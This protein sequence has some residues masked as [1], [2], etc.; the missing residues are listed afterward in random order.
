MGCG[1]STSSGGQGGKNGKM[2]SSPSIQI[3]SSAAADKELCKSPTHF[4]HLRKRKSQKSPSQQK[5]PS[6][7]RSFP[8]SPSNE[9]M[10]KLSPRFGKADN[11]SFSEKEKSTESKSEEEKEL[12]L[13][14]ARSPSRVSLTTDHQQHNNGLLSPRYGTPRKDHQNQPVSANNSP[15]PSI[16]SQNLD[17]RDPD[18][19]TYHKISNPHSKVV[20]Q[21]FGQVG[22]KE[23]GHLEHL[24]SSGI[25]RRTRPTQVVQLFQRDSDGPN[26]RAEGGRQRFAPTGWQWAGRGV[27][28]CQALVQHASYDDN[29]EKDRKLWEATNPDLFKVEKSYKGPVL[30]LPLKNSH[31]ELMIEHFKLNKTLHPR[32][33]V[34]VFHEARKLFKSMPTISYLSTS[35]SGQV[36][37]C[38]DLHGKFD[39]LC[40]ILHKNGFP[41]LDNPYV[42]NGDFVDRELPLLQGGQSIE[43]LIILLTLFILNPT[44]VSLN[45]GNHEDHIM[46]LR[47]GFVKEL[48]TKYKDSASLIIRLMEDIFSWL[49]LATVIDNDIFVAHGGISDKTDVEILKKIPRHRPPIMDLN[50]GSGKKSVNVEEWRQILDVLWSDPKTQVG[51]TANAFRGGGSYFGAGLNGYK[52]LVRSHECKYEGYEYMHDNMCLTIFSASNYYESGSNRGAYVKFL[53]KEKVAHFV[54]YMASKVHKK[55]T[56]RERLSIV[57]QSAIKELREKL[58]SF[59]T[60]LQREFTKIDSMGTGK[61]PLPV[62]CQTVERITDLN[63]PWRALAGRL[64][65]LTDDNKMV[66]YRHHVRVHVSGQNE[67][68]NDRQDNSGVTEAL[69]RHKNTLE[70]LFRFMDKD[71]S[72]LVSMKEFLDACQVLGQYTKINLNQGHIEQIAESIDFNKDGFID[73]NELL[74]AF[75]LVDLGT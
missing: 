44:A 63:V 71:N 52:L 27:Q 35:I 53:G 6:P 57:E 32:Y 45:R 11:A 75:R 66:L 9:R 2:S 47:Y 37:V 12:L 29:A 22:S 73:L 64:I 10:K 48:M 39:D 54:Q 36:T 40:I 21:M 69:Y 30:S 55:T 28:V 15:S 16:R 60:E 56:V 13:E 20:P 33:L 72:G 3:Y 17:R 62:W 7:A 59:T 43:V 58:V 49:P 26:C 41:S 19:A 46:N 51:C 38:G 25:C 68:A 74:E 18:P 5:S 34:L 50:D 23:E 61:I 4:P 42:F 65:T 1:S 24:Y 14:S 31:V 67:K 8:Q 70:T